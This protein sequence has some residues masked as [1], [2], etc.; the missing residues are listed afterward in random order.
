MTSNESTKK[1]NIKRLPEHSHTIIFKFESKKAR[2]EAINSNDFKE[3]YAE[4]AKKLINYNCQYLI[5]PTKID[6]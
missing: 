1:S 4:M 2:E 6:S 5:Q 3:I